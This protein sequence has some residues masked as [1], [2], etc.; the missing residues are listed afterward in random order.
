L[1]VVPN[2]NKEEISTFIYRGS[3]WSV[4]RGN[5]ILQNRLEVGYHQLRIREQDIQK[6]TFKTHYRHYK[7][8]VMPFRLTN[9]I[10]M[11]MEL[12]N[13]IRLFLD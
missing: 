10:V 12:M 13:W 6:K 2:D 8:L 4:K 9:A 5:S 11:L 1:K 3:V 7:F